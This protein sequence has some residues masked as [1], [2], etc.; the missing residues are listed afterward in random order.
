[1]NLAIKNAVLT[2]TRGQLINYAAVLH[3]QPTPY[4]AAGPGRN[5][6]VRPDDTFIVSYPRSGNTW[7]RFL[8]ANLIHSEV[9]VD[10]SNIEALVPDIYVTSE[11]AL[12]A[13]A[14]PRILKSHEAFDPRY[15]RVIYAVRDPRDVI[16]SQYTTLRRVRRDLVNGAFAEFVERQLRGEFDAWFGSWSANVNSWIHHDRADVDFLLIRYEDIRRDGAAVARK[17]ASFLGL[18]CSDDEIGNA[19]AKSSRG[20]MQQLYEDSGAELKHAVGAANAGH[21][22]PNDRGS[23]ALLTPEIEALIRSRYGATMAALGY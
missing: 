15:R 22:Q 13:S 23:E 8:C 1:M 19:M 3:G 12:R 16:L 10:Y 5:L 11:L 20:R 4:P 21:L 6:Q 9:Q 18:S 2:L 7:L 14:G 17:I